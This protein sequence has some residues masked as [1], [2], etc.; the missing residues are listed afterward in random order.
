MYYSSLLTPNGI[1]YCVR[2]D[3]VEIAST[4]PCESCDYFRGSLQGR[5]RECEIGEGGEMI[6]I[7][8]PY[9]YMESKQ[10]PT[11]IGE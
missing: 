7:S 2:F 8:D 5:G 1:L 3:K 4:L 11:E 6:T 9:E 10:V